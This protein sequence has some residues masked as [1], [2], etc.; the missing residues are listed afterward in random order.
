M[1]R[2]GVDLGGTNIAIGIVNEEFQIINLKWYLLF[3]ANDMFYMKYKRNAGDCA[4]F[5]NDIEIFNDIV[6]DVVNGYNRY[7]KAKCNALSQRSRPYRDQ[8]RS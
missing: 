4:Q 7:F 2:L 8:P 1:F 3:K 5:Q 6:K